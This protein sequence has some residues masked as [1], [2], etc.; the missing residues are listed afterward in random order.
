MNDSK[1][2]IWTAG[3]ALRLELEGRRRP[4]ATWWKTARSARCVITLDDLGPVLH[5]CN[6]HLDHRGACTTDSN[7]RR[8]AI[9]TTPLSPFMRLRMMGCA[10]FGDLFPPPGIPSLTW[11]GLDRERRGE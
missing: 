10:P 7:G 5:R 4:W 6:Q 3:A 2:R 8:Y 1:R 11:E 9:V